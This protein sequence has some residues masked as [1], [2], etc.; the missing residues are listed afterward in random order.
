MKTKHF[1]T[2]K[3]LWVLALCYGFFLGC[4]SDDND[5]ITFNYLSHEFEVSFRSQGT[6]PAPTM[7]WPNETG[8]FSLKN[9]ISGLV[10]DEVTGAIQWERHLGVGDHNVTVIAEDNGDTWETQ[11]LITS[12][13]SSA[14]WSGGQN[15]EVGLNKYIIDRYFE[16]FEDGTL[17]VQFYNTPDSKGVG[18]WEIHEDEIEMHFCL[19][20]ED[21]DP[22]AV[23]TYDEHSLY[24]GTLINEV[25]RAYISGQWYRVDFDPDSTTIRGNFYLEWD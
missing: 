13:L 20:C 14:F 19:Y 16:F 15:N 21:M 2:Y 7:E 12:T 10:I 25:S 9:E 6:I 18:V 17:T 22:Y 4:S 11:F 1:N 3:I 23:L 5:G 8:T 24:K